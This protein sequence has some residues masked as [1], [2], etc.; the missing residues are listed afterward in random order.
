MNVKATSMGV[1]SGISSSV[2]LSILKVFD[3]V[4]VSDLSWWIVALPFL[5][6]VVGLVTYAIMFML[7][8]FYRERKY[9]RQNEKS[10][11]R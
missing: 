6:V 1:I 5:S 11:R 3:V 10:I 4:F 9:K 2:V 8:G 7:N